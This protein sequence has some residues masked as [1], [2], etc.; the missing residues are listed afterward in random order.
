[1]C[2]ANETLIAPSKDRIRE[3]R[4][5]SNDERKRRKVIRRIIY[6]E[7]GGGGGSHWLREILIEKKLIVL[8]SSG[9][10][11][12]LNLFSKDI[13][14]IRKFSP[15]RLAFIWVE[16]LLLSP[17]DHPIS[18]SDFMHSIYSHFT[19]IFKFLCVKKKIE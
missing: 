1:M 14:D 5:C 13:V 2:G 3:R 18:P 19:C 6:W 10:G 4:R 9:C 7:R 15:N 16:V 11:K 8:F 17:S 12:S